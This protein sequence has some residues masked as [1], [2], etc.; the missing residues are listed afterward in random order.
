[1]HELRE[2]HVKKLGLRCG[3][4]QFRCHTALRAASVPAQAP[5]HTPAHTPAHAP[6][7]CW[8]SACHVVNPEKQAMWQAFRKD[9]QELRDALIGATKYGNLEAAKEVQ[10]LILIFF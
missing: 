2:D 3:G 9:R 5:A 10:Y 7:G 4:S 6:T 1:L 8:K